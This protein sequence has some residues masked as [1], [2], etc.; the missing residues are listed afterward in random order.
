[1][2]NLQ[3]TLITGA[4][5]GLGKALA[6][7]CASR[8]RNL[9]LVALPGSELPA[10]VDF[11][12]SQYCVHVV[13]IEKDL[14]EENSCHEVFDTVVK[15][16]LQV[17]MLINNAGLGSTG[18]F[19]EGSLP[20]YERQIKLNVLATTIL[21]RLFLEMLKQNSPSYILNVG[22]LASNFP[23]P[24]KHVYG[25]TKSFIY[26]FSKCLRKELQKSK[27][28]VSVICPGPL[29]TNSA[30]RKIIENGNYL[31]RNSS[32]HPEVIAPAVIDGILHKKEV[33]IPGKLNKCYVLVY[34]ILP[35]FIKTIIT[36]RSMKRLN[37][38]Q[39]ERIIL[40][41]PCAV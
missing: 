27:V 36:N 2:H 24:K 5:E 25:A 17:N 28:Y 19:A 35:E 16:G 32:F 8:K 10:L 18:L 15:S 6:I 30:T 40:Q 26:Y 33:I 9:I 23:L 29:H 34:T 20:F 31:I 7:E 38:E 12:T 1:M 39:G 13:G 37:S 22:S 21:T 4:S 3:Y 11:I 41:K 14:C